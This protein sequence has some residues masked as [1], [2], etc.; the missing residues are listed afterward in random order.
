MPERN[1]LHIVE[2]AVSLPQPLPQPSEPQRIEY[3]LPVKLRKA[4][5][6]AIPAEC[7]GQ[8][9]CES[10]RS[11]NI[12]MNSPEE[13]AKKKAEK[14]VK[15]EVRDYNKCVWARRA[16]LIIKA[17]TAITAAAGAVVRYLVRHD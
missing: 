12:R 15:D 4:I 1:V 16:A 9:E 2:P 11:Y 7:W 14:W 6:R 8:R 10:R 3:E 5:R 17:A 13:D